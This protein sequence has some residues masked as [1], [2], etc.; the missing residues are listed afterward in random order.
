MS[1][2]VDS[3]PGGSVTE[4][5]FDYMGGSGDCSIVAWNDGLTLNIRS[6]EGTPVREGYTFLGWVDDPMDPKFAL[7][8]VGTYIDIEY[9]GLIGH[10]VPSSLTLYAQWAKGTG[11]MDDPLRSS[12]DEGTTSYVCGYGTAF[13]GM[14]VSSDSEILIFGSTGGGG[15]QYHIIDSVKLNGVEF[16]EIV[17][18]YTAHVDS[19]DVEGQ[20]TVTF[21]DYR[22]EFVE[23]AS[24]EIVDFTEFPEL[25]FESNPIVDGVIEYV[26]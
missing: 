21:V 26:A 2:D 23:E 9:Y 17:N 3:A 22:K 8:P 18:R 11:T 24:F 14:Y 10:T 12:Q 16:G 5:T 15:G 7:Y 13:N 6:L 19:Q 25:L 1:C 4:V 20:L